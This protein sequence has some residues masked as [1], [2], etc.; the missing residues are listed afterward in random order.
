MQKK[1]V[2]TPTSRM[3]YSFPD[4]NS[5]FSNKNCGNLRT[6]C[7][8]FPST[9]G[10]DYH[11]NVFC[12][13]SINFSPK[14]FVRKNERQKR[15]KIYRCKQRASKKTFATYSFTDTQLIGKLT[16]NK[17]KNISTYKIKELYKRCLA[18]NFLV[19]LPYHLLSE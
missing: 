2:Q 4:S 9:T 18:I 1:L 16:W 5:V 14:S 8:P 11:G 10:L 19:L 15:K 12:R 7:T 17:N 3:I 13:G 6:F